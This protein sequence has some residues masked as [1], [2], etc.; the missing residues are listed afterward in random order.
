M[1]KNLSILGT[2]LLFSTVMLGSVPALAATPAPATAETPVTAELTIPNPPKPVPPIEPGEGGG[3][4]QEPITGV[5]GIA[6]TPASLSG[7]DALAA[8]GEQEVNLGYPVSAGSTAVTKYN[9]GVQDKTRKK[10]Q[11]WTLKASL[12]WTDDTKNYMAGTSIKTTDGIVN[13]NISGELKPTTHS[14]VSASGAELSIGETEVEV[15]QANTG[16][17]MNGVYNY[18]FQKPKLYIPEVQNVSAGKYTGNINWNL[19]TTP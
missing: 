2:T 8:K 12:S 11:S 19:S 5:F 4:K 13:E 1:K 17:T 16:Q 14:E 10:D 18:Q 15:M 6:Y 7:A 9:V 3:D